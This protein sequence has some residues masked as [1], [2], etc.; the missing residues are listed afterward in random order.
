MTMAAAL[1]AL[2]LATC[3]AA[4]VAGSQASVTW[5]ILV[6]DLHIS[7]VESGRLRTLLRAIGTDLVR[8]SD[9]IVLGTTGPPNLPATPPVV[10]REGLREAG[11]RATGNAL[12]LTVVRQ[13]IQQGGRTGE[14]P[15]RERR[16]QDAAIELLS[17][18]EGRTVTRPVLVFIS[19]G[20]PLGPKSPGTETLAARARSLNIPIV[21]ID[22]RYAG[23]SSGDPLD[24]PTTIEVVNAAGASLQALADQTSG[25]ALLAPRY[26]PYALER[27]NAVARR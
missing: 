15:L 19:S 26:L 4:Q 8:D 27:A 13:L 21:T 2:I 6:D 17:T 16:A 18:V 11:R 12:K 7:F 14:V 23:R 5:L 3:L 9:T 10:D 25:L 24:D 1:R 20:W 22:P